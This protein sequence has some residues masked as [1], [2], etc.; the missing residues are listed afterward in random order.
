ME[1]E[2][3]RGEEVEEDEEWRG[4]EKWGSKERGREV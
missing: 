2:R 3:T 4:R 1:R